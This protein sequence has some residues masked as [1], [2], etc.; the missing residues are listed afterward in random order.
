MKNIYLTGF[1]CAGKTSAGLA[2]ARLL[3]RPFADSDRTVEK[4][5]GRKAAELI[6]AGGLAAFRKK[7]AAAV[8][9]IAARGG[10]VA[11]LGGGVYPSRR[12]EK[13]LRTTGTIVYLACP[14][15]ELELRLKAARG[16]R[17]LLN[18]RWETARRRAKELYLRRLPAYR[19]ADLTVSTAGK[20]PRRTAALIKKAL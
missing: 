12:W 2:L 4:K 11:A 9:E 8:K 14:W 7:E 1:M 13:L 16:P 10:L 18:G 6:A 15:P 5:Y 3:K 19:R 20:T 17:P